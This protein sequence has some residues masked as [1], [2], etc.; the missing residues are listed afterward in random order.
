MFPKEMD[1]QYQKFVDMLNILVGRLDKMD[2]LTKDIQTMA[3]RHEEYGV[4]P[5]H[6]TM[7]GKALLWTLKSGLGNE[8]TE[9]LKQAWI[10]CYTILS[11]TMLSAT[12]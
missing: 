9:E 6:Y 8:W 7:V 10:K 12:R 11:G 1:K 2:E 5:E 3:K 4:K